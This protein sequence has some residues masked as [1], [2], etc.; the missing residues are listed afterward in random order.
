VEILYL[1]TKIIIILNRGKY[2]IMNLLKRR[3]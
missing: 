3:S 1:Y 2:I